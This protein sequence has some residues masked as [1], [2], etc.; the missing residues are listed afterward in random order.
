MVFDVA[1]FWRLDPSAVWALPLDELDRYYQ[2]AQRIN[3]E[4]QAGLNGG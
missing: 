3:E 4:R 1:W 2:N